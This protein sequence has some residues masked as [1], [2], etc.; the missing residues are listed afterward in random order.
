MKKSLAV[1]AI[2]LIMNGCHQDL[3]PKKLSSGE[4]AELSASDNAQTMITIQQAIDVTAGALAEKGIA[5]GR[6]K[7]EGS[8]DDYGCSPSVNLTLNVDRT[9]GDSLIYSGTIIINYGDGSSCSSTDKRT[10]KITDD[11]KI[12]ISSKN[13]KVFVAAETITFDNFIQ[14]G[15]SFD[16]AFKVTSAS[17]KKTK[18]VSKGM[19]LGYNDGTTSTLNGNLTFTYTNVT[20]RTGDLSI[21]GN[22][23]GTSR[24]G[25]PFTASITKDILFKSGCLGLTNKIPVSGKMSIQTNGATSDVDYGDG[26]CDK[27]YDVTAESQTKTHRFG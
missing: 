8:H 11:F 17:G 2:L 7:Q 1:V 5:E 9:H 27:T 12:A 18:V 20:T 26:T 25:M 15:S 16:G 23:S 10:G 19:N 24:Q 22:I 6:V 14:S 21:A 3:I 13:K 4:Q